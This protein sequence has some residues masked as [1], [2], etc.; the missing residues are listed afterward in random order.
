MLMALADI[1]RRQFCIMTC[2]AMM[3][4]M[5][6]M[7]CDDYDGSEDATEDAYDNYATYNT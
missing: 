2:T 4:I 1:W 7:I 3:M 6:I 5:L